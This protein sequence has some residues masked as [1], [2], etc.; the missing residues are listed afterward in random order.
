MFGCAPPN[1][2]DGFGTMRRVVSVP[3]VNTS[4]RD[5]LERLEE[6]FAGWVFLVV[7]N[8]WVWREICEAVIRVIFVVK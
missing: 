5:Y 7:V 8:D 6:V 2:D 3:P 4:K 1:W